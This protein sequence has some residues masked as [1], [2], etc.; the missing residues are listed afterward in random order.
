LG[1]LFVHVP[2]VCIQFVT[3]GSLN[4]YNVKLYCSCPS[5]IKILSPD[6]RANTWWVWSPPVGYIVHITYVIFARQF[7]HKSSHVPF[8]GKTFG[9][10]FFM[11]GMCDKWIGNPFN[12]IKE[13]RSIVNVFEEL[14]KF[15]S[16][17]KCNAYLYFFPSEFADNKIIITS[18]KPPYLCVNPFSAESVCRFDEQMTNGYSTWRLWQSLS[19]L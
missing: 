14:S 12:R 8:M 15:C 5:W 9:S 13:I 17:Q 4:L 7:Y 3:D 19:A 1:K 10:Y 16:P 11:S 6:V 2:Q 18:V